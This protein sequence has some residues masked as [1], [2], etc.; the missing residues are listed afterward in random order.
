MSLATPVDLTVSISIPSSCS[1]QSSFFW[2]LF[3]LLQTFLGEGGRGRRKGGIEL[4]CLNIVNAILNFSYTVSKQKWHSSQCTKNFTKKI[5]PG[6]PYFWWVMLFGVISISIQSSSWNSF[7]SLQNTVHDGQLQSLAFK[8]KIKTKTN[9][10]IYI[11]VQYT[12]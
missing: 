6:T 10:L 11:L 7:I 2:F 9:K 12:L 4:P 1:N 8:N 5:Q 3:P